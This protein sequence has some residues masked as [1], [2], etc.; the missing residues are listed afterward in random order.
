MARRT[1]DLLRAQEGKKASVNGATQIRA[2]VMRPE[3]VIPAGGHQILT[4][5]AEES[6][7][8]TVGS[9]IRVIRMPYFGMLGTVSELPSELQV[10]ETEARVRVLKVRFESGEEALLPRANVEMIES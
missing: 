7:G 9:P 8:L 2:G 6:V 1:F 5:D 10:L 3:I 4:G